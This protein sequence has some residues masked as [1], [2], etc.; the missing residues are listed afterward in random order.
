MLELHKIEYRIRL[1]ERL[2]DKIEKNEE[3]ESEKLARFA[4]MRMERAKITAA[5][6]CG[7]TYE[8]VWNEMTQEEYEYYKQKYLHRNGSLDGFPNSV[9]EAREKWRHHPENEE[10]IEDL[11]DRLDIT[12]SGSVN[13]QE[14]SSTNHEDNDDY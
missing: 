8:D 10:T 11:A 13:H 14:Y 3:T 9:E 12:I 4:R 5:A 6:A 2:Y 7:K 1:L